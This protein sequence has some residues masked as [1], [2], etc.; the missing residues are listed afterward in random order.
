M[1]EVPGGGTGGAQGGGTG[2]VRGGYGGG[3]TGEVQGGTGGPKIPVS[4]ARMASN[5]FSYIG[6][7]PKSYS[8]RRDR[9]LTASL[10]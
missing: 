3:Y 1:G 10:I 2:G 9:P 8:R 5:N 7:A 6:K 4:P